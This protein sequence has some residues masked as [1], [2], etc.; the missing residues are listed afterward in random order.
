MASCCPPG[1]LGAFHSDLKPKGKIEI[2]SP[3]VD[4]SGLRDMS[5]YKSVGET[6]INE[7]PK[8]VVLVFSDVFGIDTGNHKVF[9]DLLQESMGNDTQVWMPD[10]FRGNPILRD[11]GYN[12]LNS[13]PVAIAQF[14][15]HTFFVS[16]DTI[17]KDL[18]QIVVPNVVEDTGCESIGVV[19]FCFGA[20][21]VAR[22]L[23]LND[24]DSVFS[25]GVGIHP[26]WTPEQYFAKEKSSEAVLAERTKAKPLLLLPAKEDKDLMPDSPLVKDLAE[27]RSMSPEE[28]AIAFPEMRHGFVSR[29][30]SSD[31]ATREAQEKALGLTVEFLEKH[32]KPTLAE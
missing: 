14:L 11:F 28:V 3:K 1:A 23:A 20:W 25:C 13:G 19:G 31:P 30:D 2:L 9:C 12:W 18:T 21:V 26:S 5:C 32:L 27:K 6:N 29:G 15:F 22:C 17:E 7:K 10:M 8:K 4:G 24:G 16:S